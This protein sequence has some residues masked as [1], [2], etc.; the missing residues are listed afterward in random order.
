MTLQGSHGILFYAQSVTAPPK[1]EPLQQGVS[2]VCFDDPRPGTMKSVLFSQPLRLC[3]VVVVVVVVVV[4]SLWSIILCSLSSSI[5]SQS[6]PSE[7]ESKSEGE[8][9]SSQLFR[10]IGG[11]GPP[12]SA[13]AESHDTQCRSAKMVKDLF[14]TIFSSAKSLGYRRTPPSTREQLT[15]LLTKVRVIAETSKLGSTWTDLCYC[16]QLSPQ[17][18]QLSQQ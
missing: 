10:S 4:V 17:L 7:R 6:K 12:L 16:T 11:Q 15:A 9:T 8:M 14:Q 2:N 5:P 3:Y 13:P 18:S 1:D